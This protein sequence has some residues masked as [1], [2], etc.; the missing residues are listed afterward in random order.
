MTRCANC[1][2]QESN[3]CCH[4]ELNQPCIKCRHEDKDHYFNDKG[5]CLI[6]DC[7]GVEL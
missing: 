1:E 7:N 2:L 3:D 5:Q 4:E 6:C